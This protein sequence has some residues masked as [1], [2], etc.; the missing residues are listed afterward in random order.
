[1]SS[2]PSEE[3]TGRQARSEP[4]RLT[5]SSESGPP[6]GA[7]VLAASTILSNA[8]T[9]TVVANAAVAVAVAVAER[10]WHVRYERA[11]ILT[12]GRREHSPLEPT[13]KLMR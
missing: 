13:K 8:E 5:L 10:V 11:D 1:M 4:R 9:V 6:P 7:K 3:A 12:A 2:V